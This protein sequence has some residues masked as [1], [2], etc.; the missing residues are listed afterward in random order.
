VTAVLSLLCSLT[1]M[2]LW[3]TGIR[4]SGLEIYRDMHS[5][6]AFPV[7]ALL[8]AVMPPIA[9]GIGSDE[10]RRVNR[11]LRFSERR[12]RE[13]LEHSP[14]GMV[15]SDL[16]GAW[17]ETN[18]AIQRLLG[19]S[20]HEFAALPADA[21][22]HPDDVEEMRHERRRLQAR[23]FESCEAERRF[24]HRD[25]TWIWARAAVSLVFDEE[26][27]PL[28]YISQLENVEKRRAVQVALADEKER[29]KT[30][31]MAIA[32]PIITTDAEQRIISLNVAAERLLGQTLIDISG[33]RFGD[34][35]ALAHANSPNPAPDN[36][37]KCIALGSVVRR[38]QMC[39]LHRPDGSLV[40]VLDS[41]SPV[42]GADSRV[43]GTVVVLRD[44]SGDYQR[45]QDLSHRATRDALTGL[46]N[47][48]EFQRRARQSFERMRLLGIPAVILAI[49]LDGFK[50]VNDAAGHAAGDT[51]LRRVSAVLSSLARR[52]D[53]DARLGGDE[54]AIIL[55]RCSPER[56]ASIADQALKALNPLAIEWEG[57]V[58]TVGASIGVAAA[59]ESFPDEA[60]WLAAA[61]RACYEAKRAGRGRIVK[62]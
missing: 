16:S 22:V 8:A 30:I 40:H 62:A 50:A 61:D 19:F 28:H 15:I 49:D 57:S 26:G 47:R 51:M 11:E 37:G 42:F 59:T 43:A 52:S 6:Q 41:V 29:L 58:Y 24:L 44:V 38:E 33:R 39:L 7:W 1:V 5:L 53:S 35:I 36:V 45:H 12:F 55:E 10:R 3:V 4:P 21:L 17:V 27:R 46:A 23:E 34:V 9:V 54:F 18:T 13:A 48:F 2:A 31:L 25:G 14:S 56:V 60:A 20:R 32:D